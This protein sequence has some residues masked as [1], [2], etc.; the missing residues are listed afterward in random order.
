MNVID[1]S[2]PAWWAVIVAAASFL[3]AAAAL[4]VAILAWREARKSAKADSKQAA[5]AEEDRRGKLA[6]W[7]PERMDKPDLE[8]YRDG[9]ARKGRVVNTGGE[10]AL[11]VVVKGE[12][13]VRQ[14]RED[15][16][17]PR[18]GVEFEYGVS[19]EGDGIPPPEAFYVQ[20][21]W[22]RPETAGGGKKMETVLF[23]PRKLPRL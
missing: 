21:T 19:Y 23:D 20:V 10:L 22:D 15:E 7:T 8:V 3:V 4:V 11:N 16:V 12:R 14:G 17:A 2:D 6:A 5:F 13:I 9:G 18:S 1:W